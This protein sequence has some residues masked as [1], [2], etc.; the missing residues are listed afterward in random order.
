MPAGR[1]I[2]TEYW[3]FRQ[4]DCQAF[5]GKS[6]LDSAVHAS[7]LRSLTVL[8]MGGFSGALVAWGAD[9]ALRVD[10]RPAAGP[11]P[12]NKTR[13]CIAVRSLISLNSEG[14]SRHRTL[15]IIHP[16]TVRLIERRRIYFFAQGT[17]VSLHAG[18]AHAIADAIVASDPSK[19]ETWYYWTGYAE[20][21][22]FILERFANVPFPAHL[23]GHSTSPF[24]WI[25]QGPPA[26]KSAAAAAATS[27]LTPIGGRDRFAEWAVA[28]FATVQGPKAA[29]VMKLA[30]EEPGL[31]FQ[32][33]DEAFR[34][35][36]VFAAGTA[37][38][39]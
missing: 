18:R 16:Y 23:K 19:Y 26:D 10:P 28:R 12:A 22:R 37:N 31:P 8:G 13:I 35:T 9:A 14:P 1:Y 29:A 36:T 15:P 3:H 2:D 21:G 24:V 39:K 33:P 34:H 5:P 7:M 11:V 6:Q 30:G 20:Y 38:S 32:H 17:T 4:T 25:E 27:V